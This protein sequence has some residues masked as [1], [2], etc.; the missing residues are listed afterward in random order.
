MNPSKSGAGRNGRDLNSGCAC[1]ATKNGWSSS[2]TNSI[3]FPSGDV[4]E[5]TR[6]LDSSVL[7]YSGLTSFGLNGSYPRILMKG[8][9][10]AFF[11]PSSVNIFPEIEG[12]FFPRVRI[13]SI[14]SM[15]EDYNVH[16]YIFINR[17]H[18]SLLWTAI[19]WQYCPACKK[20][21]PD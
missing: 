1:V 2:S 11:V 7:I 17:F 21:L 20:M 16:I 4:P 10:R 6:P 15:R 5:K 8:I 19:G 18:K 3:S 14:K 9:T 12:M 13:S